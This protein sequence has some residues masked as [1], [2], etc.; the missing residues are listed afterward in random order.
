MSENYRTKLVDYL[1]KNIKKGYSIE[2]LKWAL[3]NQGYAKVII[4]NAV[5]QANKEL[6]KQVPAFKEKPQIKYEIIDENNNPIEI[7]KSFLKRIF[8]K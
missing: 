1:I 6:A 5:K 8:R 4:E 2:S 7:K 3:I